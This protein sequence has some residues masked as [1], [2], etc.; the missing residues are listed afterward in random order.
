MIIVS[1]YMFAPEESYTH[2]FLVCLGN[3]CLSVTTEAFCPFWAK[4]GQTVDGGKIWGWIRPWPDNG[5]RGG[6]FGWEEIGGL[7]L[8]GSRTI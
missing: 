2:Q 1:D 4:P 6:V 8:G 7:G 5:G 3:R